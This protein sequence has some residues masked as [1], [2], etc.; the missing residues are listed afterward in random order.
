LREARLPPGIVEIRVFALFGGV[1]IIVPPDL[2]VEVSGSAIFGGFAEVNRAPPQPDPDRPTLRGDG[3]AI[4]G[5]GQI[6]TRLG[7]ESDRDA[8]R[9]ERKERKALRKLERG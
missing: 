9:R 6:E 3:V 7:G 2:A 5:G 4:F 8:R 1:Q